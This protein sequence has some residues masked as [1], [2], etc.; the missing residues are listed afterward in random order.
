ML[1]VRNR[2]DP[3]EG[4]GD[5]NMTFDNQHAA[6]PES[7]MYGVR[8]SEMSIGEFRA[9]HQEYGQYMQSKGEAFAT[10]VG[11]YQIVGE[12]LFE[13]AD[14]MGLPDSTVLTPDVQDLMYERLYE[15]AE[16]VAMSTDKTLD[17][18]L[19]DIWRGLS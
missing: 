15:R 5:Y 16:N 13:L 14:Q 4:R 3:V 18:A 9:K 2:I 11:R 6:D 1:E 12:T 10:P 19:A 8:V 7:P 17:Q